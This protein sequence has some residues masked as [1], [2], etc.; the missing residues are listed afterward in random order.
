MKK[1]HG[2][3]SPEEEVPEGEVA[4]V[5]HP[6]WTGTVKSSNFV[7]QWR[8]RV[9]GRPHIN[10]SEMTAALRSEARRARRFPGHRILTGSDSQVTLGALIKGRSSSK[11]LNKHLKQWLP[12]AL[13]YNVYN[14]TQ[15]IGTADNVADDPTRD[16]RCRSPT[17][18]TPDWIRKIDLQDYKGLDD[19]LLARGLD[20]GSVARIPS[21]TEAP[22][23]CSK[24]TSSLPATRSSESPTEPAAAMRSSSQRPLSKA[25]R[26]EVNKHPKKPPVAA[27]VRSEPWLP[28]RQLTAAARGLLCDLP[29]GQFVLPRGG[30]LSALLDKPG[31]LDLFSGCRIAAQELANRTGRWVLTY[32]ILHSPTEDLLDESVQR[33]ITEMVEAG[34]FLSLTAG[35][36]CASFSRAVRPPVRSAQLP[37]G[38]A[39]I[40]EN[41]K[42]KVAVGNAMATWL[43]VLVE[44]VLELGLPFWVENPA[45]SFLWLQ[46]AWRRLV[47]KYELDSM[48]TDYCRWG[49]AW[50][51]RTRF[52][53]RFSAAGSRYLCI[54]N[55]KHVRLVGYSAEHKCCWTKAA[56][57]YPR[58]LAKYLAAALTESL[59]PAAR[60]RIIDPGTMAKCGPGRVGEASNPGPRRARANPTEDLEQVEL[61]RPATLALQARVHRSF[62]DWLESEVSADVWSSLVA[63]PHLQVMFL[64]SFGNWLYSQGKAMYLFRHLVVFLQQQFPASRH[65]IL[66]AWEL[67]ARWE[68]VL[69]V[70]HRPPLP[71][72][73]LDAMCTLALAWGWTRWCATTLLAFHG[74]CRIGEPLRAERKDL[75]LPA[76][77]A[78]ATT[79]C[80][81][82]IA[83]PK[84]GRR[85][86]GRQ[87]HTRI[88]DEGAVKLAEVVFDHLPADGFLYPSSLSSYR[89]RWDR[90]LSALEVPSSAALTPGCLRG[91]G[92]V[93]LYHSGMPLADI[94]W[95]L[96][97]KNQQ[98][99]DHYL[100][101]TAAIGVLH[102]LPKGCREK[103]T[104]CAAMYPV[105]LRH[106]IS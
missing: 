57:A 63:H 92:A 53:G 37:E 38:L 104:S 8:R 15:Y 41:M 21:E 4:A 96:R 16:R 1:L 98:T 69:P 9:R 43:A 60:Q 91:G 83:A 19:V 11:V 80:F 50:R 85:G 40:T 87:Q 14:Y 55:R 39:G 89:R 29:A 71:K 65:Q 61:V 22:V 27:V 73:V 78:L 105:M 77:A 102:M 44:R 72:L 3:L 58:S 52:L 70:S 20:D 49:T 59:K 81:L 5:E 56:E 17:M 30:K 66:P 84:P 24:S 103:V 86:C 93:F 36:V 82:N 62:L 90:I 6:L 10:V 2:T 74:A 31:R 42:L 18:E 46:P 64:R 99:L 54:C 95:V 68:L 26:T 79:V 28:R 88:T 23:S 47:E 35:P 7:M 51:K 48:L 12:H 67:L 94:Q 101:E 106:W 45:G 25:L 100:Q 76:E 34:C 32:D 33:H 13:A 75:I 97:L